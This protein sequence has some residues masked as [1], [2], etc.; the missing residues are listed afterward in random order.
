MFECSHQLSGQ[1]WQEES[2]GGTLKLS[3]FM[4]SQFIIMNMFNK[5]ITIEEMSSGQVIDVQQSDMLVL[6]RPTGRREAIKFKAI[7]KDSKKKALVNGQ[8]PLLLD[9][10][11]LSVMNILVVHEEGGSSF[12]DLF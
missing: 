8:D 9:T 10:S 5:D 3:N 7:L 2:A 4:M 12:A 6:A 1:N 11:D